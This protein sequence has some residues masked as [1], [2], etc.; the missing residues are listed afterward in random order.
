MPDSHLPPSD[1]D[2]GE[3]LVTTS[4][5]PVVCLACGC[6]CDDLAVTL[7][8]EVVAG[9]E[10]RCEVADAWFRRAGADEEGLPL[11]EVEGRPATMPEAVMRAAEL[12]AGARAPV[13]LG[14]ES[15]TNQATAAAGRI[16][17]LALALIDPSSPMSLARSMAVSRTGRV[18]ATLGEVKN[19]ADVVVFWGADPVRTHPR[20]WERYSV[21]AR[22]RFI[23]EGETGRSV[24]VVDER[25]TATAERANHF[26]PIERHREFEV[27][28]TLRAMIRGVELDSDRVRRTTGLDCEMLLELA[29]RLKQARY[30][31][32]FYVP[33]AAAVFEADPPAGDRQPGHRTRHLTHGHSTSGFGLP[34]SNPSDASRTGLVVAL[35]GFLPGGPS[36][37][38]SP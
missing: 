28:W 22:G 38:H 1:P 17:D 24:I 33:Q 14:L 37:V 35:A 2:L 6:Q 7:S 36:A 34:A 32:M 18:S 23:H 15:S 9:V 25:K 5:E 19:R 4:I 11:A 3:G 13:I 10:P 29:G 31:A 16:A 8:G 26:L 21:A 27:L 12:L 30:G 20:H